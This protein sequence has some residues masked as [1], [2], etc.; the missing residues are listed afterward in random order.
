MP[1]ITQGAVVPLGVGPS[2]WLLTPRP[3]FRAVFLSRPQRTDLIIF[4]GPFRQ[5][6]HP[7]IHADI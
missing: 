1:T 5:N 2:P 6:H 4:F 3:N 7:T